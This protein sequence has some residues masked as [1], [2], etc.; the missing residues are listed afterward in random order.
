VLGCT[1]VLPCWLAATLAGHRRGWPPCWLAV[2]LDAPCS[3]AP[4]QA[5]RARV[6]QGQLAGPHHRPPRPS[7]RPLR[8]SVMH[9]GKREEDTVAN[10]ARSWACVV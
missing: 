5:G 8:R 1:G 10:K 4:A 6:E 9:G 2:A 7:R 3:H